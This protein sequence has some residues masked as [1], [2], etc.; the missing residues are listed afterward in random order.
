MPGFSTEPPTVTRWLANSLTNTVT[1][2][3][4]R[5][6]SRIA[7][8]DVLFSSSTVRPATST[9]P[10]SG[11]DTWPALLTRT[12][13]SEVLDLEDGDGQQVAG[14]DAVFG[15]ADRRG[16]G[17]G[18]R[19]RGRRIGMGRKPGA[20]A[21]EQDG[22]A[23]GQS[24]QDGHEAVLP[25]KRQR[26]R[27]ANSGRRGSVSSQRARRACPENY[28]WSE[29]TS[30]SWRFR[31]LQ[32]AIVVV[33]SGSRYQ[34]RHAVPLLGQVLQPLAEEG[35]HAHAV[36]DHF[37]RRRVHADHVLPAAADVAMRGFDLARVAVQ[38]QE[39]ADGSGSPVTG[40]GMRIG[41]CAVRSV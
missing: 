23:G 36:A 18:G 30:T 39:C 29:I 25:R 22:R 19:Q 34:R 26:P 6:R 21:H 15:A 32:A 17:I 33:S 24:K 37:G 10:I 41:Q 11:S 7:R 8:G 40:S 28:S 12:S 20:G 38:A 4:C 35:V 2:G 27:D 3:S 16:D 31:A 5:K 1:C 13:R 9:V 14:A